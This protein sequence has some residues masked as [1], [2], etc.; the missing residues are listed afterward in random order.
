MFERLVGFC[1]HESEPL[2]FQQAPSWIPYKKD[3]HAAIYELF[4]SF[5]DAK[6]STTSQ[7]MTPASPSR[8]L[9]IRASPEAP[10]RPVGLTTKIATTTRMETHLPSSPPT[11]SR[12]STGTLT[13]KPVASTTKIRTTSQYGIHSSSSPTSSVRSPS[14]T[15]SLPAALTT[16]IRT[17]TK[18]GSYSSSRPAVS[19]LSTTETTKILTATRINASPSSLSPATFSRAYVAN[20]SSLVVLKTTTVTAAQIETHPSPSLTFSSRSHAVTLFPMLTTDS[21]TSGE[22]PGTQK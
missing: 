21:P 16:K 10:S 18:V 19:I 15:L 5:L 8:S 1:F 3:D 14:K 6:N 11:S 12:A 7:I 22:K 20:S 2:A 17:A 13:L 9:S 4:V